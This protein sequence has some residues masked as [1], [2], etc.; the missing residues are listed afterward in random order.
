M[1][2]LLRTDFNLDY[3]NNDA[4]LSEWLYYH[5]MQGVGHIYVYTFT[6]ISQTV[7]LQPELW[8]PFIER[9]LVTH[10]HWP[11]TR[12]CELNQHNHKSSYTTRCDIDQTVQFWA[13]N[14]YLYNFGEFSNYT[15][16]VDVDE[17]MVGPSVH[18]SCITL[19]WA[20]CTGAYIRIRRAALHDGSFRRGGNGWSAF[21]KCRLQL[22]V[23]KPEQ[24]LRT[25]V[26]ECRKIRSVLSRQRPRQ[27]HCS[28]SAGVCAGPPPRARIRDERRFRHGHPRCSENTPPS[29]RR[30][31]PRNVCRKNVPETPASA[32]SISRRQRHPHEKHFI[33]GRTFWLDGELHQAATQLRP[34]ASARS[35]Q[36]CQRAGGG[37]FQA[38]SVV[39]AQAVTLRRLAAL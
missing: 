19:T 15:V 31:Q 5:L 35:L 1:V 26:A 10:I 7:N 30:P 36:C 3:A 2:C 21:C 23:E 18:G 8:R 14:H 13:Y 25:R 9:G 12:F 29:Q 33:A 6:G 4:L 34:I 38:A 39:G 27:V 28:K 20:L 37:R 22:V 16:V 17:F 11:M 32:E 24:H